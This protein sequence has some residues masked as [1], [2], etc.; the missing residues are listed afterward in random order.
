MVAHKVLQ[1]FYREMNTNLESIVQHWL[2][3]KLELQKLYQSAKFFSD[4][5]NNAIIVGVGKGYDLP[6]S[7]IVNNYESIDFLDVDRITLTETKQKFDE[8]SQGKINLINE[9][10][11][12]LQMDKIQEIISCLFINNTAAERLLSALIRDLQVPKINNGQETYSLA[13]SST[14]STQLIIPFVQTVEE[15]QHNGLITLAKQFGDIVAEMH[16]QQVWQLLKEESGVG[17]LTSE[18]YAW[19]FIDS[20]TMLPL[21]G[22]VGTAELM[23][24]ETIQ[25]QIEHKGGTYF[26]NGRITSEMINKY[27]PAKNRLLTK[28]WL[29]HFSEN[30]TYLIKGWVISK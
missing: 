18:Q 5:F 15:T 9:D 2:P 27:I 4:D 8:Q 19:G 10:I 7:E 30:L 20:N 23:L 25:N 17:V 22:L 1:N 11:V 24:D 29:W 3:H 28:Q 12:A 21:N 6:L 13:L 26:I 16:V 14:V